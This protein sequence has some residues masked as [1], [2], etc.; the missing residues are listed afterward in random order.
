MRRVL[1]ICARIFQFA[2]A[3][4]HAE[5]QL[6]LA[7]RTRLGTLTTSSPKRNLE[8]LSHQ[9]L[10]QARHKAVGHGQVFR[11]Q[12]RLHKLAFQLADVGRILQQL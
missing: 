8:R 9:Q 2:P 11:V 7:R 1:G 6:N 3:G 12:T 10:H 5:E 4:K